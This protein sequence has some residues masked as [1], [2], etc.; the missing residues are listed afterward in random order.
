MA[1]PSLSFITPRANSAI[2]SCRLSLVSLHEIFIA[3]LLHATR[4]SA[5]PMHLFSSIYA[6]LP[7]APLRTLFFSSIAPDGQWMMRSEERR[8]G[9]EGRSRWW[10]HH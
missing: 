8:V 1:F 3:S 6:F 2:F 9:K 7:F 10:P 5:Q 4:Q